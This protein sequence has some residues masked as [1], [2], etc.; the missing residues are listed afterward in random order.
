MLSL[1][2]H[3]IESLSKFVIIIYK[4]L[5]I[6]SSYKLSEKLA[7]YLIKERYS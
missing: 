4:H 3:I 1:S 2:D 7:S 5:E 6:I